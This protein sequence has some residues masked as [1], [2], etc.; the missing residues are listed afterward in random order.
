MRF[1][2]KYFTR[3]RFTAW[4]LAV[5]LVTGLTMIPVGAQ[6]PDEADALNAEAMEETQ[7]ADAQDPASDASE[8]V[9][10]RRGGDSFKSPQAA[11]QFN[12]R[13][14]ALKQKLAG[15]A[16]GKVHE[17]AKGQYVELGL[18][19][20]DR[21]FV[22]LVEYGSQAPTTQGLPTAAGPLHNQIPQP[23]RTKDNNTIWQPDYNREH[24]QDMYFNQMVNY[25]KEQSSG[26]YTI[27]GDVTE[28]V[29]VPFN[30]PRYGA[31]SLGDAAAWTLIADA[32]NIWTKKQL[33]SGMT[34][35]QVKAYLQTFD[36]WDRYDYDHDGNFDESDG[37]IDHFQIVHSGAGEETGG[38]TLGA[39]AIWSHRWFAWYNRRT[40]SGPSY[41]KYGGVE[42]G[43]GWGPTPRA[44]QLT[45][46]PLRSPA[47]TPPRHRPSPMRIRP[48]ALAYGSAT[49]RSSLKTA[50]S[51]FS[52]TSTATTSACRI[53]TTQTAAQTRPA[54]GTSCLAAHTWA[55]AR[56][57]LAR[58][59]AI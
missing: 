39:N 16:S 42:F 12:L 47:P 6:N 51:A 52:R 1:N 26:R 20:N 55:M 34:L 3:F 15:K 30:G 45:R 4:L 50:A 27:N 36:Q 7:G 29:K 8:Q 44:V 49:T 54:S 31:N 57:T 43:G 46:Q 21:V 58:D 9:F 23:D 56:Q 22:V 18:E 19:R 40:V 48:T 37:Y 35:D 14:E 24:F 17:V 5:I 10:K 33:D 38:G 25:Y 13:Q 28:W 11:E 41:N 59:R 2:A 53:T 32:I